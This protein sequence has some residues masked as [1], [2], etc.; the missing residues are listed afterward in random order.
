MKSDR[1]NSARGLVIAHARGDASEGEGYA[2]SKVS[3]KNIAGNEKAL[4][5][6]MIIRTLYGMTNAG[7][8]SV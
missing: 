8:N 6:K 1:K 2:L 4:Y 3:D 5:E 7:R